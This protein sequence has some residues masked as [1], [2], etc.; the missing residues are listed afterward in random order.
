[1]YVDADS[2]EEKKML[3]CR[4]R[5]LRPRGLPTRGWSWILGARGDHH[6]LI[7]AQL[8][9]IGD[10]GMLQ[11]VENRKHSTKFSQ[12]KFSDCCFRLRGLT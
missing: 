8:R 1:M 6:Q 12:N 9:V 7:S 4:L 3:I 11:A 10:A 2:V 5:I